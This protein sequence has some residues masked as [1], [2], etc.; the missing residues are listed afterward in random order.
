[1]L[2]RKIGRRLPAL[3]A[4]CVS[5]LVFAPD[6][7][8]HAVLEETRPASGS[9]VQ[10]TPEQ[11]LLRFDQA[12]DTSLGQA[13]QVFDASGERVDAGEI[14]RPT[15]QQVA[16][17]IDTDLPD[18][19]YTVAWRAISADTDPIRGAFVFH[20][21]APG[22]N[23]EGIAAEVAPDSPL[24]LD[25]L[26]RGG[27]FLEFALTLLCAGGVAALVYALR[28]ADAR[29]R[30]RLY[31]LLAVAAA[32]LALWS[33]LGLAFQ[34]AKAGGGG[35]GD[36][37]TWDNVSGVA[38]TRYGKVELIRA[39]LALGLLGA[40]LVLRRAGGPAREAVNAAAVLL[41]A[42][43]VVTPSFAGHASAS[44]TLASAADMAHVLAAA[45]WVGGLAFV[46]VALWLA[47]EQRWPLATRAVPRFST[48]ATGSVAVLLVA[49]TVNGYLQVETW[50]GLWETNYGLLLLAKIGLILPLLA[51]G[52]Y[53]NRYAV[54]RL[55]AGIAQPAE[56]RR[57]V[58]AAGAELTIMV[59]IIGV[60][61]FLVDSN[62]AK[63]ALDQE[64]AA[65]THGEMTGH[66]GGAMSHEVDFG[67]FGAT[68]SVQ[69]GT[70]GENKIILEV[71]H[72]RPDAPRLAEVVFKATLRQ[73]DVGP[74]EFEA[75]SAGRGIWEVE[76]ADLSIA[77]TWELQIECLVGE[78]DLFT[79]TIPIEIGASS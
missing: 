39:G 72:S 11:V 21:G 38:G 17:A 50:R 41:A 42:G 36:A 26:Y 4:A 13:L 69:P 48:M 49:G 8:A 16:V 27:R 3:V 23:P 58:R 64:A 28:S 71:D 61:A 32:L 6:A 51:L 30:L 44:G 43:L 40:A 45:A 73:P 53:N 12:V 31:G 56:R 24:S 52:A 37:F 7:A 47:L 29:V 74:L 79:E 68:V 25:V 67:E 35:L 33:L 10:Q 63:H 60:T 65:A 54:P 22:A 55:R 75:K 19:T 77:G 5:L 18:G 62:P 76:A 70:P 34:G 1:L 14:L 46:V 59:A 57:F 78:F 2:T 15:P 66:P 9:V 20:V